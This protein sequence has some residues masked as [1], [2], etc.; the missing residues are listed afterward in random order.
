MKLLRACEEVVLD[1]LASYE[2]IDRLRDLNP[3]AAI[4]HPNCPQDIWWYLARSHPR[5]ARSSVLF[6]LFA[7]EEPGRWQR[8]E[9]A[10]AE[11]WTMNF[12]HDNLSIDRRR[13]FVIEMIEEWLPAFEEE[14]PGDVRPREAVT[15]H[16]RWVHYDFGLLDLQ[17]A[18]AASLAAAKEAHDSPMTCPVLVSS[19]AI[20]ASEMKPENALAQIARGVDE[21]WGWIWKR[22]Q[23]YPQGATK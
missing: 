9:E 18:Q 21:G 12:M 15:A 22:I 6:A 2:E 17:K 13:L 5:E 4:Q 10:C 7:L 8:L 16:R 23:A 14:R 3:F 19:V 1:P 20:A 11:N